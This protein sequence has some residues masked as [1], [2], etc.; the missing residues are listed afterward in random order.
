MPSSLDPNHPEAADVERDIA[1][2]DTGA[3]DRMEFTMRALQML[4]A[5]STRVVLCE[6]HARVHVQHGRA[7]GP[8]RCRRWAIVSVPPRASRRAIALAVA[9]LADGRAAP[10]A[11]D[12]L[13][14]E[15]DGDPYRDRTHP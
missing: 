14:G 15:E 2:E 6:G 12:V 8:S 9:E 7:W 5:P 11:L 13:L 10:Y 3:F 1:E 4:C